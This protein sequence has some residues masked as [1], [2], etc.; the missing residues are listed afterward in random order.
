VRYLLVGLGNLG[1][2]RL[3]VLG[4]R[5][6]A[7]VD[8][9]NSAATFADPDA[10]PPDRYD[11]AILAVP[12]ETKLPLLRSFLGRGKHVLVEKPLLFACREEAERL[13]RLAREHNAIWYTSYNH[14]LEP[15]IVRLK[16]YLDHGA[17]GRLYHGRL[18]YGN[19]TARTILGTWREQGRGVLE[20][21]GSHLLDLADYL[22]GY[23]G[24]R[25]VGWSLRRN[26]LATFDHVVLAAADERLVLEASYLCWKNTFTVDLY[27]ERGSVHLN[28]LVK[29]GPSELVVRKRVFPSGRPEE[30]VERQPA[31][32]DPTWERD[33]ERFESLCAAGRSSVQNDIWIS[34]VLDAVA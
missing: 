1:Q 23:G 16:H 14:R 18:F 15:L 26:E 11:C 30:T 24:S 10:C 6:V 29:W 31:G 34:S 33:L 21:L 19:G 5:C 3:A 28:G 12:N 17:I 20:D 32:D 4:D 13:D 2:K 25:F 22:L 8:P 9:Y 27:G 7:T